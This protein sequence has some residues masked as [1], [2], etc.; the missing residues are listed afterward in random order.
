[1][2]YRLRPMLPELIFCNFKG[3]LISRRQDTDMLGSAQDPHLDV[4]TIDT[5]EHSWLQYLGGR[6]VGNYT[7][8]KQQEAREIARGEIEVVHSG[9]HGNSPLP[10]QALYQSQCFN[11]KFYV[12]MR[13]R[14]V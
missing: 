7:A 8:L 13:G 5:S 6:C 11:L 12:K 14:F 9:N 10:V 4:D 2:H 1:M 3:D